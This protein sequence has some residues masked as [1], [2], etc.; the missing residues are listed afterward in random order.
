M[1]YA[2][3][4][5]F[6]RLNKVMNN[7]ILVGLEAARR[8]L[9]LMEK[10]Y[11]LSKYSIPTKPGKDGYFRVMVKDGT[12]K[13]GRTTIA[14]KTLDE[15][16]SKL[17]DRE[18]MGDNFSDIYKRASE[19]KL[20]YIKKPEKRLSVQN[21]INR[22]DSTYRRYF[23]DTTFESMP[24]CSISK[25]DIEKIT[26][27]NLT[28][29]DL[30]SKGLAN[31][32]TILKMV[33]DYAFDEELIFDNPY[34]RVNFKKF[35]DMLVD[36]P[37][38][39]Q[40]AHSEDDMNRMLNYIHNDQNERPAYVTPYALE[41]QLLT[42]MRRGEIPPLTWDDIFDTHI[43]IHREQI[44]VRRYD[45]VPEHF[46][47]VEHTKTY[48]DRVFPITTSVRKFLTKLK[49]MQDE[50]YN[51]SSF[52]F[53]ADRPNGCITNNMVYIYYRDMCGKLGIEIRKD[54]LKGT[55]AFRRTHITKFVNRTGG[56]VFTAAEIYGN[57]VDVAKRFYYTG[58]DLEK[59]RLA[60]E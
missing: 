46:E 39:T 3:A 28:K 15:L 19:A 10:R 2:W 41:L 45:G 26:L 21:T 8:Q 56:D 12:K 40:R 42:G 51:S 1:L 34:L 60:L 54:L 18:Q 25:K 57:S 35:D 5:L 7:D 50:H 11:V 9:E 30:T 20:A 27:E 17:Y 33:F 43:S 52:L 6:L 16:L 14:A 24:V 48:K 31:Y 55:H 47:I 22:N 58:I 23:A 37:S 44:T 38:I 13:S 32:K 53:P 59:A 4:L 49:K 29:Y 36:P